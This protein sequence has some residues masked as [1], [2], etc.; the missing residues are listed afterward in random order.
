MV[1]NVGKIK[2][3]NVVLFFSLAV[4]F[5]IAGYLVSDSKAFKKTHI[6]K[7]IQK[8]PEIRI[9]DYFPRKEKKEF[10]R[11]MFE[12]REKLIPVQSGVFHSQKEILEAISEIQVDEAKLRQAFQKHQNTN[13][14]LQTTVNDIVVKM[15]MEMDYQTRLS[16]IERGK[17]AHQHRKIMRERW[18]N[19]RAHMKERRRVLSEAD[20]AQ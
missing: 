14:S 7:I 11:L 5:F 8:R 15:L 4:N 9:V 16:I 20:N 1:D 19:D 3:I 12:Q 2:W 17:K 10:R 18:Q 6:K 13:S